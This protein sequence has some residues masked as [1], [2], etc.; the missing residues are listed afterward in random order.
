VYIYIHKYLQSHYTVLHH[1]YIY[2]YIYIY[3]HTHTSEQKEFHYQKLRMFTKQRNF[4]IV[5][6]RKLD[7]TMCLVQT[8]HVACTSS[9]FGWTL[10][11]CETESSDGKSAKG[12]LWRRLWWN[13]SLRDY[14]FPTWSYSGMLRTIHWDLFTDVSRLPVGPIVKGFLYYWLDP[15]RWD[16]SGCLE[17][18]VN[19]YR[20]TLCK[21]ATRAK[22]SYCKSRNNRELKKSSYMNCFS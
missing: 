12:C 11:D 4:R 20:S 3:T 2:I 21:N 7:P 9:Q 18:S 14:R 6:S 16:P 8:S 22:I 1:L 17:T 10:P 19:N 5:K 15:W 13:F